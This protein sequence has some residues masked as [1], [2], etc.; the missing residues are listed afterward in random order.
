VL[1]ACPILCINESA[2][3]R[4]IFVYFNFNTTHVTGLLGFLGCATTLQIFENEKKDTLYCNRSSP[5]GSP[6]LWH[7]E[8]VSLPLFSERILRRRA[9]MKHPHLVPGSDV[10]VL[11]AESNLLTIEID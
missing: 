3:W 8:F 6:A 4:C 2:R 1:V 9:R 7:V 11:V 5:A 10:D